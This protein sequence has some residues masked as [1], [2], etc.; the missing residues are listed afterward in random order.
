M[1]ND[2]WQDASV[3]LPLNR[4]LSGRTMQMLLT[5]GHEKRTTERPPDEPPSAVLIRGTQK[6]TSS[7]AIRPTGFATRLRM[8]RIREQLNT[9]SRGFR[10][11]E[12]LLN[13]LSRCL[14]PRR[15]LLLE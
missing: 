4:W 13:R 10:S 1:D 14:P 8:S 2:S 12:L 7:H 11:T 5:R 3:A 15:R 6:R 9:K